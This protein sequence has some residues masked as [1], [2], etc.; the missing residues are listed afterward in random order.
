ME[1][2]CSQQR[3]QPK[4]YH[5][6]IW[7]LPRF[8][9][10]R[11]DEKLFMEYTESQKQRAIPRL[12][13]TGL[14][15]Q[16]FTVI[17]PGELDFV[18]AY[19]LT[20]TAVIANLTL[21]A[22]HYYVRSKRSIISHLA[23]VVLWAQLLAS[24]LRRQGDAY[25]ELLGWAALLQYLT[26]A[27]LPF[28]ALTLIIYS[29]LSFSAYILVQYFNALMFEGRL[30]QDF[31]YQ[32]ICNGSI[33]FCASLLGTTSFVLYQNQHRHSFVETKRSLRDKMRKDLGLID[34][35]F[36]KI[37]MS[38][39]ENV[40]YVQQTTN[41]PVDM[42]VGIHTGAVLA[43]VLGQRQ[44]QFDVYSRDVELANKMESSG[45]AGRVHVSEVTLGFLNDE[46]EVEP[47][48]G[49]KREEM[50]R[51]AGIKTYFIVKVLKP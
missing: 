20:S 3:P 17:V 19:A 32:E 27:T 26:L 36:K 12:L 29:I 25:D 40:R 4:T 48:F 50:L 49:E 7:F 22:L 43:G 5:F 24:A 39:H 34:T 41:S 38:R 46:F 1:Y 15:L 18:F 2:P 42:R 9:T 44:W 23:W 6:R 14:I 47:A 30:P 45:L 37:Y 16:L 33:L 13:V 35:Q 51:Q 10:P 31:L 21:L 8:F 11:R 28:R